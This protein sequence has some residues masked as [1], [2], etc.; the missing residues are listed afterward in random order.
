MKCGAFSDAGVNTQIEFGP[1][2][3]CI[4]PTKGIN[5]GSNAAKMI[6][7]GNYFAT[8]VDSTHDQTINN[9]EISGYI[10]VGNEYAD[11]VSVDAD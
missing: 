5:S 6:V 8:A 4:S 9:M 1:G 7:C 11:E 10:C 2:N 3:I